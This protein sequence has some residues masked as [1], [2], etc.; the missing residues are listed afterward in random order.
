MNNKVTYIDNDNKE[1]GHEAVNYLQA[2]GHRK[3][4]FVTDDLIW[5]SR[6]GTLS[7]V[8]VKRLDEF[9]FG[10]LILN[11]FFQLES[12]ESLK[13]EL[14]RSSQLTALIVKDDLDC[15]SAHSLAK[16]SGIQSS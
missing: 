6:T 13:E 3:I 2:K 15:P 5:A 10:C 7:R 14:D 8:S 11:L 1:L 9:K 12:I 16:Q 4:G